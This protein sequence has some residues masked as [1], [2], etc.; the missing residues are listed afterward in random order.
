MVEARGG[1]DGVTETMHT[2]YKGDIFSF[3]HHSS[4]NR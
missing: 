2:F 3:D 1:H 4:R